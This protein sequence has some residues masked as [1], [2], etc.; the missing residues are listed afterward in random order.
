MNQPET[1]IPGPRF[2]ALAALVLVA[3]LALFACTS[4]PTPAPDTPTPAPTPTAETAAPATAAPAAT[5]D[6]ATLSL[7]LDF[8]IET[9]Q[10]ESYAAGTQISFSRFFDGKPVI[11]N[12]WAGLCPPCRAEMPDF[13][14][15][16]ENFKDQVTLV[17][18]DVGQY[19]LLGD[20]DDAKDLLSDLGITYPTGFTSDSSVTKKYEVLGMPTTVFLNPDGTVFRNWNGILTRGQLD[21]LAIE[22]LA[23]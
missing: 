5:V 11:L 18:V 15:F 22:L 6:P 7:P 12:F 8:P 19:V 20:K 3:A 21:N 16:H 14:L 1:S 2:I 17:G 13:Q 9:Y 4:S 23:Q 10:G